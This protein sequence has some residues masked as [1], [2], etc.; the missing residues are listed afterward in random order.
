MEIEKQ[1]PDLRNPHHRRLLVRDIAKATDFLR[2]R[3]PL[4]PEEVASRNKKTEKPKLSIENVF[5]DI[6]NFPSKIDALR[7][8]MRAVEALRSE[9]NNI[10]TVS[11]QQNLK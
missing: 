9:S 7:T 3:Y 11:Q 10:D 2:S 4:T 5:F 1:A 6:N 8:F